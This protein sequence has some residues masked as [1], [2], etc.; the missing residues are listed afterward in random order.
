MKPND[1][2]NLRRIVE[3]ADELERV[4]E[5]RGITPS[6][7]T[8]DRFIQWAVTTPLYS[9]GEYVSHLSKDL[10]SQ[11]PDVPWS[12]VSG[13]RHRLVHDYEGTN[14]NVITQVLFEDL[15]LFIQQVRD[16]LKDS[17]SR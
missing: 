1:E 7:V 2:R 17:Q 16:L 12:K 15:P 14:W 6:L 8:S 13:L 5:E 11:Y 9:I 10:K 4:I 3:F